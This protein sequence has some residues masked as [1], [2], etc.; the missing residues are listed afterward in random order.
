MPI[1]QRLFPFLSWIKD[2]SGA[3]FKADILTGIT[4]GIIL[5]PQGM[6]Y[7]MIAGMPPVYGLYSALIPPL[8]Y[9]IFGTSRHIAIGPVALDSLFVMTIVGALATEGTDKFVEIALLL[10]LMVGVFQFLF[11]ILR[12]GF[13]V[14]FLGRPV[15][16]GFTTAA[17]IIIALNQLVHLTGVPVIRSSKVHEILISF[18]DGI[19]NIHGFSLLLSAV[20]IGFVLI[21]RRMKMKFPAALPLVIIGVLG[22]YFFNLETFGFKLVGNIP[23]G[24]PAF[25]LPKFDLTIIQRIWPYAMALGL[26]GFMESI[27]IGKVI[28]EKHEYQ[29]KPN[30]ELIALGLSNSIG[31]LFSAY[32]TTASFSRSAIADQSGGKTPFIGVVAGI[33]VLITLLFLTPIFYFLPKTI[34]GVIIFM[35]VLKLIDLKLPKQLWKTSKKDFIMYL[36]ALL[37]TM[38]I[39]IQFG[40]GIGVLIALILLLHTISVPHIAIMAEVE[41]KPG[42]FKNVKRFN[43]LNE[44]ED[45]LIIRFDARLF[46]ANINYFQEQIK[47]SVDQK[48]ENLKFIILDCSGINSVDATA[49]HTLRRLN[50][51]YKKKGIQLLFSNLKGPLRDYFKQED[52]YRQFGKEH[53]FATTKEAVNYTKG[54]KNSG[55]DEITFQT[56][57]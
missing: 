55:F 37:P 14:N 49:I 35:S 22:A 25:Q 32:V 21:W 33:V 42:I 13:I 8:V 11:G 19:K 28:E 51:S 29:L 50:I 7:A 10:T 38:F 12:L 15:I 27:S 20:L 48:R 41:G 52:I 1:L 23:E 17:A 40:L 6:A 26:L 9:T 18:F 47:N 36:G 46:Y 5:I 2:Y 44:E 53:F 57:V 45:L 30:K 39:G 3:D 54:E 56:D 34:L 24:L 16:A 4:L 31:S 43:N